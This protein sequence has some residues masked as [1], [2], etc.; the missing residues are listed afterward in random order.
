MSGK[1]VNLRR[2]RKRK[3]RED[4]R[5]EADASAARHGEAKAVKS[6]RAAREELEARR[7]DGHR[8][9]DSDDRQ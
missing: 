7:L 4:A 3:T 8:R 1:L 5:A 2:A 6:L 9:T